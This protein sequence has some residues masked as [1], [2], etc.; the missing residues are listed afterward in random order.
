MS[1]A[2]Q[3]PDCFELD[4]TIYKRDLRRFFVDLRKQAHHIY[5]LLSGAPK[6][7]F[8]IVQ[9]NDD[10]YEEE[11]RFSVHEFFGNLG[12]FHSRKDTF[13][14][15]FNA[16]IFRDEWDECIEG[17]Q[18]MDNPFNGEM[19]YEIINTDE[20]SVEVFEKE[21]LY[22]FAHL[23]RQQIL[24]N[25]PF[26]LNRETIKCYKFTFEDVRQLRE[27]ANQYNGRIVAELREQYERLAALDC[28]HELPKVKRDRKP[29]AEPPPVKKERTPRKK[30]I[31][32]YPSTHF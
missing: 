23:C 20:L 29:A 19:K 4:A 16:Y 9:E 18:Y 1:R 26:T 12:K 3:A 11:K 6:S 5:A 13:R 22:L 32:K 31:R 27:V 25:A 24:A 8:W 7:V 14:V 2:A 21:W 10:I 30:N 17:W 28:L 15:Y